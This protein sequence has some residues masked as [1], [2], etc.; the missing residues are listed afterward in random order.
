MCAPDR[1]AHTSSCSPAAARN[2][3]LAA[4]L[5]VCPWPARYLASF[6]IVVVLPEPLTPTTRI[7]ARRSAARWSCSSG[8]RTATTSRRSTPA[9]SPPGSNPSRTRA[10]QVG[11]ASGAHVRLDQ[12]FLQLL[13]GDVGHAAPEERPDALAE[14]S[15]G[16]LERGGRRGRAQIVVREGVLVRTEDRAPASD[17]DGTGDHAEERDAEEDQDGE[18]GPR[19]VDRFALRHL[20]RFGLFV[21]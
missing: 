18:H 7:T 6:P 20:H 3:S 8:P 11:R 9:G 10:H 1:C 2:V 16:N 5:T 14:P 13:P 21:R 4:R 15:R 19:L 17:H 12:E